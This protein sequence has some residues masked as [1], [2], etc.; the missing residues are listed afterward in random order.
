MYVGHYK[1]LDAA[2]DDAVVDHFSLWYFKSKNFVW[3]MASNL[4]R[5][6]AYQITA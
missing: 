4:T 1:V 6:T 5:S 2:N 3:I